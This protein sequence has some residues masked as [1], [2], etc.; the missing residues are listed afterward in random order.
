MR[1]KAKLTAVE[2]RGHLEAWRRSGWTL[3]AYA[4][5]VGMSFQRLHRW[6]RKLGGTRGRTGTG[7]VPVR[8]VEA[9]EEASGGEAGFELVSRSGL[10]LRLEREFDEAG[11]E[12][13]LRVMGRA[14]C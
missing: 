12:R 4:R 14:G 11:L 3:T 13:L 7:F 6:R 1:A 10:R 9:E 8:I 2:A 5:S